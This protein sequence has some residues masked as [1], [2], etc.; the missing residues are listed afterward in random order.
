MICTRVW[1]VNVILA[2]KVGVSDLAP[3]RQLYSRH[4]L[5]SWTEYCRDLLWM[6]CLDD[7]GCESNGFGWVL[8]FAMD[9]RPSLVDTGDAAAITVAQWNGITR[10][11]QMHG[12]EYSLCIGL[13]C[14]HVSITHLHSLYFEWKT[15][16][17]SHLHIRVFCESMHTQ[18]LRVP[19]HAQSTRLTY[20]PLTSFLPVQVSNPASWIRNSQLSMSWTIDALTVRT[21]ALL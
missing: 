15:S 6:Y 12:L 1:T 17:N 20:S 13:W 10:L 11:M 19:Q 4:L 3:I 2:S 21:R 5:A 16:Q 9:P 14:N 18:T 7:L 8:E